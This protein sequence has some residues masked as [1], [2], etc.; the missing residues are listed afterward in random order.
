MVGTP[1]SEHRT[2][3]AFFH[4]TTLRR[5]D[6]GGANNSL[7]NRL[8]QVAA[9]IQLSL[10]IDGRPAT[11][12]SANI[13]Q[14]GQIPVTNSGVPTASII[15]AI[16]SGVIGTGK[17]STCLTSADRV[18]AGAAEGV[19]REARPSSLHV[20]RQSELLGRRVGFRVR[21]E[22]EWNLRGVVRSE[23]W[24]SLCVCKRSVEVVT[25][26]GYADVSCRIGPECCRLGDC[27]RASLDELQ[28]FVHIGKS[29]Q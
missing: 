12:Y 22:D 8:V 29:D 23:L 11:L 21:A 14:D 18:P 7:I 25:P 27:Q 13:T 16:H 20:G 19:L 17:D 2:F 1:H 26:G 4:T 24:V 28:G 10:R 9:I 15:D 5:W 3:Q 6:S